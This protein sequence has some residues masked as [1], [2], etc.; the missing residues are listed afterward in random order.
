MIRPGYGVELFPLEVC[1]W[2]HTFGVSKQPSLLCKA[3]EAKEMAYQVPCVL[4]EIT[5]VIFDLVLLVTSTK[6]HISDF[7]LWTR[8][9]VLVRGR[10]R[11]LS[12]CP[13][14]MLKSQPICHMGWHHIVVEPSGSCEQL[15]KSPHRSCSYGVV[16]SQAPGLWA[17][18][19]TWH[20]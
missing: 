16:I 19:A 11:V 9:T 10:L 18:P 2:R 1:A 5:I 7:G 13:F 12:S 4:D 3:L 17:P 6:I 15:M 14:Y 20:N 8:A